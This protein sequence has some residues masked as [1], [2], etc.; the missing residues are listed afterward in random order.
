MIASDTPT[1]KLFAP[2]SRYLDTYR[3]FH[4]RVQRG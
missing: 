3:S 2:L 4:R 1:D